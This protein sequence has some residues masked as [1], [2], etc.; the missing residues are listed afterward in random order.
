MITHGSRKLLLPL[1]T[2]LEHVGN[3]G[4]FVE[5]ANDA[6][7]ASKVSQAQ[8]RTA[9]AIVDSQIF[10]R[11]LAQSLMLSISSLRCRRDLPSSAGGVIAS[12]AVATRD[13]DCLSRV[14]G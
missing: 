13:H 6:R 8:S 3:K 11:R 10:I 1:R 12:N 7:E 14:V 9:C 2:F 5:T 4:S